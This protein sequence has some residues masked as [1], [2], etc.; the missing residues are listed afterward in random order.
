MKNKNFVIGILTGL[1]LT[2]CTIIIMGF[3]SVTP[4]PNSNQG[5]YLPVV[6]G[7]KIYRLNTQTGYHYF[8]TNSFD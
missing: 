7:D 2:L 8:S 6:K 4:P 5:K 3:S 1:C